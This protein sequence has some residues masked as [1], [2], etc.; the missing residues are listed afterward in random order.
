MPN[1]RHRP[2]TVPWQKTFAKYKA[3][4]AHCPQDGWQ[5]VFTWKRKGLSPHD[6]ISSPMS[7]WTANLGLTRATFSLSTRTAVATVISMLLAQLL[8]LPERS[9]EHT[10]EL[11]SL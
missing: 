7:H 2:V 5:G 4:L 1:S 9:E 11:Q 8:K 10:Y 3:E 6:T